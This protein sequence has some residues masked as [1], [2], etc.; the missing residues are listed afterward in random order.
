[1]AS[2]LGPFEKAL[3]AASNTVVDW[4]R[5]LKER[6]VSVAEHLSNERK[7]ILPT[8][9]HASV[10][11]L[12]ILNVVYLCLPLVVFLTFV[13]SVGQWNVAAVLILALILG[14]IVWISRGAA[15][16]IRGPCSLA[17]R[18]LAPPVSL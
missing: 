10:P 2:S 8:E 3:S 11:T 7:F 14:N 13:V 18:T 5:M 12:F 9:G 6:H 4:V 1:L 16:A 17:D 15:T